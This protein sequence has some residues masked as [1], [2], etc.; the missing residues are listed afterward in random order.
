MGIMRFGP[1]TELILRLKQAFGTAT[2]IETGT[3]LGGTALWA[4]KVFDRVITIE[5]SEELY[6]QVVEKFGRIK[7]IEFMLGD[8]KEKLADVAAGLKGPAIFWLDAHWSGGATSGEN[9]QC[10]LLEEIK[11]I[12]D[13]EYEHFIFIDDARLFMSPPPE[14]LLV[15]QW[16]DIAT[17]INALKNCD[18][19]RY[20]VIIEDVLIAA[21]LLAKTELSTYCQKLNTRLWK[22]YGKDQ[23][24]KNPVLPAERS[25]S[26]QSAR[27]FT[28]APPGK[29]DPAPALRHTVPMPE[30]CESGF[31][32]APLT[33]HEIEVIGKFIS[34]GDVVFDVGAYM[35]GWTREV[36]RQH[37]DVR[38]HLFEPVPT[39]YR[40]LE[41]EFSG[42]IHT[43]QVVVNNLAV[44]SREET[45]Q[46]YFYTDR[47]AWSTFHRRLVV[48]KQTTVQG[49][50]TLN[51]CTMMIEKY[52][53]EKN[54]ERINFLKIDTEGNELEVLK[55]AEEL[56]RNGRIDYL[57][58]EYGGTFSDAGITL[59]DVFEYLRRMQYEMFRLSDGAPKRITYITSAE[60]DYKYCNYLAVNERFKS[61]V[62]GQPTAMPDF[63]Q[64]CARYGIRPRGIIHIGA[65][66]GKEA[67]KYLRMGA[68]KVLLIEANPAVYER[69]KANVAGLAGVQ[70]VNCA[71][72]NVNGSTTLHVTSM[73]QSSSIL[74]LKHHRQ[75]YPKITEVGRITVRCCTLD[76]LLGEMGLSPSDFNIINIDIQGAELLAFQGA[77]DLL[78][79]VDC[80]NTEVNYEELYEGCA[81]IEQIDDFLKGF[82]FERK[83]VTSPYHWSW[84]DA[85]Y[86]R[87]VKSEV[88]D[89]PVITVTS[90]GRDGRFGNQ[91]FQYAFLKIYAKQHNLDVQAPNWIGQSL[92]GHTDKLVLQRR[93]KVKEK[94]ND[95]AKA[96]IPNARE[97]FENVDFQG[98]FQYHT[99]FYAPY[100]DYFRRL[101]E[102][103]EEIRRRLEKAMEVLRQMG[104]TVVG[105]HLRRADYGY[106]H[107]FVAPSQW[108]K[109]W[110]KNLWLGLDKPVLFIA[111][112]EPEI[113]TA[114]F[115]E[116]EP[117]TS[118]QLGLD[119]PAAEFYP[120][121]YILSQC[122]IV[123]ISNSSFSF[124][125]C[126]LNERGKAFYRP[127]L[128]Q[129]SLI[130]F[131]PW[132]SEPILRDEV[133]SKTFYTPQQIKQMQQ[134][135]CHDKAAEELAAKGIEELERGSV[136]E[137]MNYFDGSAML[138]AGLAERMCS[139][140]LSK[141][142][143]PTL[144]QIEDMAG[145]RLLVG[146]K[147]KGAKLLL[148]GCRHQ[149]EGHDLFKK[150]MEKLRTAEPGEALS[151]FAK[152]ATAFPELVNLHFAMATAYAQLGKLYS[153]KKECEVELKLQPTHSGVK[154][155]LDRINRA[156][157]E[158]ERSK[159]EKILR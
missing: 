154:E 81:Q 119:W 107:F 4:S 44:S 47:P 40:R 64:Q 42:E 15:N 53:R 122:D 57:Q 1:P 141:L 97:R 128:S 28:V 11:T 83:A 14:P 121:F 63:R 151:C 20:I 145:Q 148:E 60:E 33:K 92:F 142:D 24:Q 68:E 93:P 49:P 129:Q 43:G 8:S 115:R 13:S 132:N 104:K 87:A 79:H 66:E 91:L 80:I 25:E 136:I 5:A 133:V 146:P 9:A 67:E 61:K 12:N 89:R 73:D 101:F 153:A 75:I 147:N 48:E 110:L 51:V 159:E 41:E 16:P 21:P 58:F 126:M 69:L 111:S 70:T 139:R 105:L 143:K 116:Y 52:C 19:D 130:P 88:A 123:A 59:E 85:F 109:E 108:Y 2:F 82:G 99:S 72:S 118:E 10:P 27:F 37:R 45:R 138:S 78:K 155:L 36:F 117:V 135:K 137:T 62:A 30:R 144:K 3:Y 6:K 95:L 125:A 65:H 131:D 84:G 29:S 106:G 152:T 18:K 34:P 98:Y 157:V 113:V 140:A 96:L 55:G 50:K 112:D 76:T 54:I 46:I 158:Y 149:L 90:L 77:A 71:I 56:L 38:A 32:Q 156:I 39:S 23:V 114:D 31:P 127:R 120:D 150:G 22:E 17:V 100:K 35:G 74:P 134:S 26:Q 103:V 7:H 86:V 102:P 94:S 124:L